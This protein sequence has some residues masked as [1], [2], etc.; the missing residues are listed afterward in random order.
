VLT[1]LLATGIVLGVLIFVHELGHFAAAKLVDIEVPRFSIGMGPKAVGFRWGE[2]EYVLSWLPLGGYV[3]MAGMGEEEAFEGLEG[4][5]EEGSEHREPSERDFDAKPLPARALVISAGVIMNGLFA[6]VAFTA[7]AAIWGVPP[8]PRS[9]LGGVDEAALPPGT[10]ALARVPSGSDIDSIDG[11]AVQNWNDLTL[12]LATA[13]AGPVRIHFRDVGAVTIPMPSTDSLRN[14]LIGALQPD[15]TLPALISEVQSGSPADSAGFEVGDRVVE[16]AGRP[17]SGWQAFVQIIKERPGERLPVV[18]ER[19]GSRVSLTAVPEPRSVTAGDDTL[20]FG[21]LGV[22]LSSGVLARELAPVR[23]GPLET[24]QVGLSETWRWI[25][26]T[27]D[28]VVGLVTR[29]VSP[30]SLGGPILIGKISGQAARMGLSA[31][32]RFMAIL[33]INLAILNLMPIP[34]LDGG[35]LMF[36]AIEGVRGRPLS[37]DTRLRWTRVGLFIVAAIMIWAIASDALRLFGG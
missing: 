13:E 26:T 23:V 28:V 11:K 16:A 1:T 15:L 20:R 5:P 34:V 32:L 9:R 18:I 30:H 2:T 36:L 8:V 12:A 21:Y 3:K 29:T 4:G 19:D 27:V 14:A 33:S 7:I 37:L 24:V 25:R 17:V 10:F 6:V 22:G 31:L 35:H